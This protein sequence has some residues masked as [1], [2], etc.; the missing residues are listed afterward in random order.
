MTL[1]GANII[2][3]SEFFFW[4]NKHTHTHTQGREKEV[5]TQVHQNSTQK[6]W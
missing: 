4:T 3:K 5:L 2:Y 1:Y 6:P